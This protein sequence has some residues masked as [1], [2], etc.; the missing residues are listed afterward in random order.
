MMM[1]TVIMM[2][3]MMMLLINIYWMRE[4]LRRLTLAKSLIIQ[5]ITSYYKKYWW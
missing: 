5:D 1:M 2:V 3:K 4:G